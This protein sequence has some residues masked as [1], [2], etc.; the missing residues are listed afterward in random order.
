MKRTLALSLAAALMANSATPSIVDNPRFKTLGTV[1]VWAADSASGAPIVSDFILDTGTGAT[2]AASGD[3]DLIDTD[4]H[5]VVTGSLIAT[6]DSNA[7]VVGSMPFL[8]DNTGSGTVNTD[9]N[10]DGILTDADSFSAFA[11][12]GAS[13]ERVNTTQTRSSFYVASNVPF[14]IDAQAVPPTT[15]LGLTLLIITFLE[16]SASIDSD[17]EI[18]FGS[19]AQYPHS[20]GPTG[21][22]DPIRRLSTLF[23]ADRIFEGNQATAESPGS[24]LDQSVRFDLTYTINAANL[25]G[26]D[27]SL[28]TFD[29]EV[30]MIYTVY[31]P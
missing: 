14:A 15:G 28:G 26:Y 22:V 6:Q 17:G 20:D 5:T 30:D 23:A 24:I 29:F 11:L 31:V 21:G 8:I 2:A 4:V 10:G 25:Q 1:I 27:L 19:A 18:N 3:A 7:S 9:S 12:T 13:D 16:V